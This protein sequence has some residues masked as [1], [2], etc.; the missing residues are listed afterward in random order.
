[1]RALRV[2]AVVAFI[3]SSPSLALAEV[4]SVSISSRSPVAD[5]QVFGSS[6]A[7]EKLTGTIEFAL[8][9]HDAHNATIVDLDRAPRASDGRVHFKADLYVLR[10]TDASKGNGVLL[11]EVS[12]RGRKG[13]L[14]LF[15][16]TAGSADPSTP[17]DFGNGFLM[18]EGYTL[19]WV[20]WEFD[21]SPPLL[22]LEA[23]PATG[24]V[25]P[26]TVPFIPD[27]PQNEIVLTDAPLYPPMDPDDPSARLTVRDRFWDQPVPIPHDR[28][29]F[30]L[31]AGA[32]RIAL[33][34]GFMPGRI[35]E[36]TY[37]AT[38]A[39]VVGAGLAAIRDAASAFRYRSDLPI[40]GR[41]S[42]AF[43]MSQDGRFLREF[44]YDGFNVD[45]RNRR[46]FD[47][48]WSHIAGAARGSFNQRFGM[49][50]SLGLFR[51]TQFP[52]SNDPETYKGQRDG[53][54][55]RYRADQRPK[56]IYTNTSIEYWG[57]GRAAA[58][59]HTSPDGQTDLTIPDD[60][61]IY[62]LAGTQHVQAV[63]PPSP[64][65]GQQLP[66]PVPQREVMRALLRGLRE[67][68]SKGVRPPESRYPKLADGSLTP[69]KSVKFPAIPGVADPRTIVGPALATANG[70]EP[71]PFLVPQVDADGNELAGIR[72]PDLT[73]P[74]ATNTGW[75]FRS[76]SIG[77]PGDIVMLMGSWIPFPT[78]PAERAARHDPRLSIEER[79]HNRDEYL[80][81]LKAAAERLVRDRYLLD[82]DIAN[83]IRRG[84]AQWDFLMAH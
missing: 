80:Q 71:L 75:N 35:Y 56:V 63:F 57:F 34:G 8:D 16:N 20:G 84:E 32:P 7:Y 53:L 69:V 2:I 52:F 12:N 38:G 21:V 1:M 5:G 77:N 11:F 25:G 33:D 66:N 14:A 6:G 24:V 40:Q 48:V 41:S 65:R 23:P 45:E 76:P 81:R 67:W 46:V 29:R 36:V 78:I 13:L 39:R 79:Y 19:V 83:V 62:F 26:I 49:P 18:R 22:H 82:E 51:P 74:M 58:L 27:S 15:N 43:G 64:S 70:I 55:A 37:V 10:P 50:I 4:V 31:G 28:W 44:L 17:D 9:P 30:V 60:E 54:L 42:Y 68:V 73:V 59:I 3:M 47:A 72:V 61:R